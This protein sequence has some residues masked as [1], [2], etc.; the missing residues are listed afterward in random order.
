MRSETDELERIG[1]EIWL[2]P[3]VEGLDGWRLRHAYGLTGRANSVWPNGDGLLPL[4]EKIDRAESWYRERSRPPAFQITQAARPPGL[5]A[6]L[7]RRGYI[8]RTAPVSVQTAA[9]DDVVERT[10]GDAELSEELDDAWLEL[11]AGTRGFDRVDVARALLTGGRAAFA[12]VD[13]VAV[14]RGSIVGEWLGITSMVTLPDAR[15]RGHGRAILH[16]LAGWG[17]EAGC[18]HALLQVERGN[19]AAATLY[20]R[21]GFAPHHDYHYRVLS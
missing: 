16:T 11:W 4:E 13:G 15:R 3:E 21:A 7:A 5:D 10:D 1:Y 14:G 12:R 2:A 18:T 20:G 6:V 17:A 9:L 19:V 8:V